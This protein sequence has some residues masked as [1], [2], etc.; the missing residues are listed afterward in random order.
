MSENTSLRLEL[1]SIRER[2]RALKVEFVEHENRFEVYLDR[3]YD[4]ERWREAEM[5]RRVSRASSPIDLTGD[6]DSD[7]EDEVV[8]IPGFPAEFPWTLVPLEEAPTSGEVRTFS[9]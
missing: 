3:L 4:L 2:Y 9:L 6:P 1:D 5:A 8:E 7:S